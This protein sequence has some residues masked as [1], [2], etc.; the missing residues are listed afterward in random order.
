MGPSIWFNSIQ[1][2]QNVSK[3]VEERTDK[4]LRTI[5]RE[6]LLGFLLMWVLGLQGLG[7]S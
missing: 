6:E 2:Q 1:N 4:V 5:S 3:L 7:F